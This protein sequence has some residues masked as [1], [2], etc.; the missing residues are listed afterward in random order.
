MDA[1]DAELA[2]IG[3]GADSEDVRDR[4]LGGVRLGRRGLR[5]A[6]GLV[7]EGV[8]VAFRGVGAQIGHDSHELTHACARARRDEADGDEMALAKR[9]LKGVLELLR[10]DR[11]L[12][13][14]LLHE[15]FIG[16]HDLVDDGGVKVG[17]L[18]EVACPGGV[19]ET[20][21]NLL[22]A[23][24]GQVDGPAHAAECLLHRLQEIGQ[25]GGV[26]DLV[27]DDHAGQAAFLG[28]LHQAAGH[29]A[30]SHQGVDD[31]QRC[32]H[33]RQHAERPAD[34]VRRPR[35]IDQVD[36]RPVG[37]KVHQ[38]AVETVA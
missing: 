23:F 2:D 9:R 33:R 26:V 16:F 20:V 31:D 25:S 29:R 34:E 18:P 12:L 5:L 35:G 7:F 22:C 4:R 21:D 30:D 11:A 15:R 32:F 8:G 3:V 14:I 36:V 1:E 19:L 13:Q 17:D 24:S 10:I 27:D 28:H 6:V 38:G 37:V